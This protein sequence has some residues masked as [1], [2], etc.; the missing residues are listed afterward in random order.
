MKALCKFYDARPL[1]WTNKNTGEIKNGWIQPYDL[2]QGASLRQ[3]QGEIMRM[4]KGEVVAPGEY[5]VDYFL[6]K[7]NNN[8][9]NL[10]FINYRPIKVENK[11][12]AIAS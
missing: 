9:L 5:E 1:T 10:T 2:D 6:E 8:R 12:Q 4:N 3:L 7:S 11:P